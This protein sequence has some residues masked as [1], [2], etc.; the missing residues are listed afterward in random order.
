[1]LDGWLN[2]PGLTDKDVMTGV[3]EFLLAGQHESLSRVNQTWS[4]I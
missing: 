1:M 3:A 4:S 2:S